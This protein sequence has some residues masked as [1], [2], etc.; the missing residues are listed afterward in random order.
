[1]RQRSLGV[2]VGSV[3][4]KLALLDESDGVLHSSYEKHHGRPLE[5]LSR[6]LERIETG[7]THQS[8]EPMLVAVTGSGRAMVGSVLDVTPVNEIIAQATATAHLHPGTRTIIEIGG[9]DSKLVCLSEASTSTDPILATQR[10][11]D[12][13]AAGTGAFVEQQAIRLK[14]PIEEF[15]DVAL[16]SEV[17]SFVAGRCAVFSKTDV[18]HLLQEGAAQP[19]IAAGICT[20]IARNYIAQFS[21]GK[22]LPTPI[23]FQGGLAANKGVVKAFR[24]LLGVGEEALFIPDDYKVTG[25]IGAALAGRTEQPGRRPPVS[26][27]DLRARLADHLAGVDEAQA[28]IS[29]LPR[30]QRRDRPRIEVPSRQP[31]PGETVYIGIDVGSTSSCIAVISSDDH[32]LGRSYQLNEG[33]VISSVHTALDEL[34]RE[35]GT[36]LETLE[37]GGVGVTGSGRALI[38]RYLGADVVKDEISAQARAATFFDSEVDTVL[39]IGGQD[40]K[41]I[42]LDRGRVVDF[43][44]NKVCAAGTGSFLLEQA[45]NLD[46]AI[47]QLSE[48]AFASSAPVD[49]GS[50]CTVFMES[51]LVNFQQLG[52]SKSDLI[53]GLSFSIARNYLEKVAIG[54]QIGNRV[55]MLGGVA[56]NDSVV[57]AFEHLLERELIVPGGREVSAAIGMALL[58]REEQDRTASGQTTFVGF[59]RQPDEVE[60]STLACGGCSNECRISRLVAGEMSF[61]YGGVCGKHERTGRREAELP[62]PFTERDRLLLGGLYAGTDQS[63]TPRRGRIGVPRTHLFFELF[64]S[65]CAFLQELGYEVVLSQTTTSAVVSE[66]L[67]RTQIDNCFASKIVYGHVVDLISQ[68]VSAVFLPTVIEPERRQRDLERN[69]SCPHIQAIPALIGQSF[70]DLEIISP[71]FARERRETDWEDALRRCGISLGVPREQV[72]RAVRRASAAQAEHVEQREQ[73]AQRTLREI[74][75]GTPVGVLLG[76]VYNVCDPGL[77]LRVVDRLRER[78]VVTLPFDCLPISEEPLPQNFIDMVWSSGQD[79]IRAARLILRDPRL[80]P[81]LVTN[82]GCGP[83]SFVIKYLRELFKDRSFLVLE[84]DEHTSAVG[85]VT[86]IEAFLNHIQKAAPSDCSA[87]TAEFQPYVPSKR[88]TL[89]DRILYMPVGF[90]SYRPIAAAFES[91]GIRTKLLPSHD[92][93]TKELGRIHSYGTEC[94]PYIMHVGDA[95]R[96]TEDPE[97]HPDRA[98]LYLPASDLACRVSLFPTSIRLVLRDIGYPDIPFVAPRLSVEKDEMLKYFGMKFAQN[99]FR[100]ITSVELLWRLSA[101]IRPFERTP[102]TTDSVYED[103]IDSIC[104]SLVDG[105]FASTL[106]QILRRFDAIQTDPDPQRPVI[107]LVGNLSY[108]SNLRLNRKA[109]ADLK[110]SV[111]DRI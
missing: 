23:A 16:A 8:A 4:L 68:G 66:G 72:D 60:V 29:T 26:L 95:V 10:M 62:N 31:T 39:E 55:M 70:P 36:S 5:C 93:R 40:S 75:P 102:G 97:F 18:I 42:L 58:T 78:G 109:Y 99:L 100:G 103:S 74:S 30:L 49:L 11:N 90:D 63:E 91:V 44:M 38:A 111:R 67:E 12:L 73:L 19:D 43:E 89:K 15:G 22:S 41:L 3:T 71:T 51:D 96:M 32:L 65:W 92:E 107:G 80:H 59:D 61:L 82:F 50:R 1:M 85:M 2:D 25:A 88:S 21:K 57:A 33:N 106:D 86:R 13:C 28:S 6:A 94:L 108:R 69:Y 47:E 14:I 27:H 35:M 37:I 105:R 53:A 104:R 83:D 34:R 45:A 81:I 84:V 24:E 76:K 98:A 110:S 101:Q 7:K 77:N 48:I 54:K 17:P 20:A 79:L 64:P 87:E 52:C 46:V 56:L 9:Q